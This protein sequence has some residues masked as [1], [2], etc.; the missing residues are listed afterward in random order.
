MT[1]VIQW[2]ADCLLKSLCPLLELLSVSCISCDVLL[3][4]TVRTHLTPLVVIAAKPYLSD[5][6][7]LAVL[8]DF[9]RVDMAVIVDDRHI[10]C[11]IME[12][13]FC[14]V[15]CQKEIFSHKCFHNNILS[16]LR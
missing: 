11:V 3:V 4:D 7:K 10:F 13:L 12:Q 5:V 14:C 15:S 16:F 8:I 9:L 1:P 6:L 2:I